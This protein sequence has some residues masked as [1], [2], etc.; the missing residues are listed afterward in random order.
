MEGRQGGCETTLATHRKNSRLYSALYIGSESK[1]TIHANSL[2][3]S[4]LPK[5]QE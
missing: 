5:H 2:G 1:C 3:L 4:G